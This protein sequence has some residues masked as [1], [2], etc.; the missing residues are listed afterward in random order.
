[1]LLNSTFTKSV[2][3]ISDRSRRC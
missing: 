3:S 2:E 1:M